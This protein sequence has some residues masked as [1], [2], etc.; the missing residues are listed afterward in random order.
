[1]SQPRLIMKAKIKTRQLESSIMK[2]SSARLYSSI[3]TLHKQN[4]LEAQVCKDGD[5][6]LTH[7]LEQSDF[8]NEKE[9]VF[10]NNCAIFFCNSARKLL[11]R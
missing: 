6:I 4:G 10:P 3:P 9:L 11:K 2:L 7:L 5:N 8:R 1:M